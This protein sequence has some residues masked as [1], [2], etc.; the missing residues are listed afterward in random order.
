M[1]SKEHPGFE[2]VARRIS[3]QQ[4]VSMDRARAMLAAGTRRASPTARKANPRLNRVKG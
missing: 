1:A 2:N 4:G 3:R